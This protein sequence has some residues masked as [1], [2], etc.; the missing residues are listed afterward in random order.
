MKKLGIIVPYRDRPQQLAIFKKTINEYLDI[1]FELIIV[2]QVDS[3]EFNRG[4]LLNIGFTKAE[5]LK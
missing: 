4:K 5:E 3:L 2:D 1:P